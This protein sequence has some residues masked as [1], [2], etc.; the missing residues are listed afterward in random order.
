MAKA[1]RTYRFRTKVHGEVT[2]Y[3][4][5]DDLALEE[6][7]RRGYLETDIIEIY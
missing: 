3:E 2:I 6:F 4:S 5:T 7:L 1:L